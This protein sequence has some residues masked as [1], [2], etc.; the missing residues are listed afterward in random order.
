MSLDFTL[1]GNR[2]HTHPSYEECNVDDATL[3]EHVDAETAAALLANGQAV[4]CEHC[5]P[6][7]GAQIDTP[8]L[9][10]RGP[11]D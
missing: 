6:D 8:T 4:A 7:P 10:T 11:D 3:V 9:N 2:L 1:V 5:T